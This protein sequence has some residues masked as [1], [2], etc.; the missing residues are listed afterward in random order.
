MRAAASPG[1]GTRW[2]QE[3]VPWAGSC[4]VLPPLPYP[5]HLCHPTTFHLNQ[6]SRTSDSM[7]TC[8]FGRHPYGPATGKP[9]EAV[10]FCTAAKH[11]APC[12]GV[13]SAGVMWLSGGAGAEAPGSIPCLV[14][15]VGGGCRVLSLSCQPGSSFSKDHFRTVLIP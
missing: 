6:R 12:W 8:D 4:S 14:L 1:E 7:G 11:G 13:I 3:A 15:G 10:C 5:H 2:L 9:R